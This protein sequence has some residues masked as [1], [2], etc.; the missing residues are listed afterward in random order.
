MPRT[1]REDSRLIATCGSRECRECAGSMLGRERAWSSAAETS[2]QRARAL[3]ASGVDDRAMTERDRDLAN[4]HA[5]AVSE[6]MIGSD[7]SGCTS[8]IDG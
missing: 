2:V 4:E 6:H 5:R 8:M 3:G 1:E 7:G